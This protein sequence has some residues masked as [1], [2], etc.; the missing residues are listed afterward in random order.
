MPES[1]T[2]RPLAPR[3]PNPI[4]NL[5]EW[6][7]VAI[8]LGDPHLDTGRHP[9]VIVENTHG[10]SRV[11]L[12]TETFEQAI[13]RA[14]QIR[15]DAESIGFDAWHRKWDLPEDFLTRRRRSQ[16]PS[17]IERLRAK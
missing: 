7:I 17:F 1:F 15:A 2:I 11:L 10:V 14:D 12:E 9:G 8:S 4:K 3:P 13:Q 5:I 16:S 6:I